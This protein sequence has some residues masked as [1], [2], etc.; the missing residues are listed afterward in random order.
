M[1]MPEPPTNDVTTPRA[2]ERNAASEAL[3]R[4]TTDDLLRFGWVPIMTGVIFAGGAYPIVIG[5]GGVAVSL[6]EGV[7]SLLHGVPADWDSAPAIIATAPF[8][9]C[10][11]AVVGMFL[12][13]VIAVFTF[14]L[15]HLFL[16]SL[17]LPANPIRVGAWYGGLVGFIGVLPVSLAASGDVNSSTG[18]WAWFVLAMGPGLTMPLGQLGGTL[19]G[20]RAWQEAVERDARYRRLAAEW[21]TG[22]DPPA[23]GCTG[24]AEGAAT[25]HLQFRIVHLMWAAVWLSILLTIIRLSGIAYRLVV[26]VLLG[27]LAYQA[28]L[29]WIGQHLIPRLWRRWRAGAANLFHVKQPAE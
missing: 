3:V 27:G 13:G 12:T 28:A 9:A 25:Q 24:A 14:P 29:L 8:I 7:W 2:F 22:L 19:G 20:R 6:C 26:P 18:W 23:I 10:A 21:Q 11:V 17:A 1:M 4:Y 16:W 5:V 15:A